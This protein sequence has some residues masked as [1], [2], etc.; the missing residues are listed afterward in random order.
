MTSLDHPL[1][2]EA[3]HIDHMGH[4]NNAVY[5]NWVQEA[6]LT[7]WEKL[8]PE[9]A[10]A[11]YLWVALKHEITYRKAGFLEDNLVAS[12]V[13]TRVRGVRAF[14]RTVIRRGED[15]LAEVESVWCSLDADTRR[16]FR[17][18]RDVVRAFLPD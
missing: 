1:D 9:A 16:P 12:V 7:H 14:Y 6:V 5:L 4:V 3:A 10:R 11:S 8:A 17:L 2:I 13:L 18:P 15:V